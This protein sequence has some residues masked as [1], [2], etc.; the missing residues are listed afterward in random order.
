[1][2]EMVLFIWLTTMYDNEYLYGKDVEVPEIDPLSVARRVEL[3]QDNLDELLEVNYFI[4]D[5]VRCNAIIRAIAFWRGIN[6]K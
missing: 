4:R 5:G 3:L 1:M 2:V 6:S